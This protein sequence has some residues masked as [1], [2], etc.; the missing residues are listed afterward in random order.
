M[1]A[2]RCKGMLE[3]LLQDKENNC[4]KA[5]DVNE[6]RKELLK[7]FDNKQHIQ[8]S[9]QAIKPS[10]PVQKLKSIL[11]ENHGTVHKAVQEH[12][13][14][15]VNYLVDKQ[16]QLQF[17][18]SYMKNKEGIN[19][20]MRA[21][22]VDWL[23]DVAAKFRM[24]FQT[25]FLT[26]HFLDQYCQNSDVDKSEYQ[27]LGIACILVASKTE[28]VYPP[29]TSRYTQ[30]CDHAFT[31]PQILEMEQKVLQVLN[32]EV[33][34]PTM[35]SLL[36]TINCE[37]KL[38]RIHLCYALYI[39]ENSLLELSI[40]KSNYFTIVRGALYLVSKIY[41]LNSLEEKMLNHNSIQPEGVRNCAKDLYLVLKRNEK[42]PLKA[43]SRKFSSED[44]CEVSKY[45]LEKNQ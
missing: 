39:L 14:E 41:N 23:I 8:K 32:F 13:P 11:K 29:H 15:I 28:E 4:N 17:D 30:I 34:P 36:E 12:F 25:I 26:I 18:H 43:S 21:I 1:P 24:A 33:H 22:L 5:Q 35:I 40:F 31:L 45:R 6:Q 42:I 19:T 3:K 16:E 38:E 27:L 44:L 7:P 10:K 9:S 2:N 20:R 37:L